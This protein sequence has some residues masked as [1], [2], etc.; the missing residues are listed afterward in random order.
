MS[1]AT[2]APSLLRG[3]VKMPVAET[4]RVSVSFGSGEETR[5]ILLLHKTRS[6]FH[7]PI[8]QLI[9]LTTF[10]GIS[11]SCICSEAPPRLER[12]AMSLPDVGNFSKDGSRNTTEVN[13]V[14]F[15]PRNVLF[16][17]HFFLRILQIDEPRRKTTLFD[18]SRDAHKKC[19]LLCWPEVTKVGNHW[20]LKNT[21]V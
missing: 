21:D 6:L 4:T 13:C 18:W 3:E 15:F 5:C 1:L 8:P 11:S 10:Q 2:P 20:L 17:P 14:Y 12:N 9:R 16:C 7:R 19:L